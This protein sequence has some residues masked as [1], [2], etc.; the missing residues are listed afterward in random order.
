[1]YAGAS[2]IINGMYSRTL[3]ITAIAIA[4]LSGF[5]SSASADDDQCSYDR[6]AMLAL[7]L[8]AFDQDMQGGWRSVA[9]KEGCE[10]AA[11]DL[12]REY[13]FE[14]DSTEGILFFHEAQ[15]RAM[16]GQTER[17]LVMFL[18]TRKPA[19]EDDWFGWN[20]YVDA[21]MA[22]IRKDRPALVEART[23]LVNLP[24]PEDFNPVDS[25]G[26]PVEMIW[27]PNLNVVDGFRE[28]FDKN[29]DEAYNTCSR[30]FKR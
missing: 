16:A 21:T 4:L 23:Q 3:A 25:H 6:A 1:M 9:H 13:I 22:F 5:V 17:A 28:C 7:D 12:I 19:D 30:P 2:G 14:H 18:R 29:Y 8:N 24:R 26:N 20:H 27:P 11:A 10:A 15:L